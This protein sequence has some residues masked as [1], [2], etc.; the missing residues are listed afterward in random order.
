MC[1]QSQLYLH[2]LQGDNHDV[3]CRPKICS[4]NCGHN[5]DH[6]CPLSCEKIVQ[7]G[8]FSFTLS[9]N[10]QI[11][12]RCHQFPSA[13][14]TISELKKTFI[15]KIKGCLHQFLLLTLKRKMNHTQMRQ[16]WMT[17]LLMKTT[18]MEKMTR[19][20]IKSTQ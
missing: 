19:K 5:C 8:S 15:R 20:L 18:I 3:Q 11:F 2:E 10:D 4:C 1:H 13:I 16:Q 17:L 9:N 12:E 6:L 14:V 7:K